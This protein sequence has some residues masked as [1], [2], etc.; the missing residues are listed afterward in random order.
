MSTRLKALP[1]ISYDLG[2]GDNE[3]IIKPAWIFIAALLFIST[4]HC[5]GSVL[6]HLEE[7][8]QRAG[9]LKK[10][11]ILGGKVGSHYFSYLFLQYRLF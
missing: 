3:A 5:N 8:Y 4:E 9:E 1:K 2:D 10:P 6:K 11:A 7:D